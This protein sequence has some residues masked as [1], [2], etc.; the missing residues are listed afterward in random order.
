MTVFEILHKLILGPVEL[1]F[2]VIFSCSMDFSRSALFSIVV[3]SLA[4]NLLVLPLYKKAD[5]LQQEE[6]ETAKRLKPRID[7]IKEAFTGDERFMI[8]Q[9]F[10]RQ[11]NYK[12]YYVLRGSLSLLLQIPFFMAAYNFLSGLSV[13]KGVPF[14]PLGIVDLSAPDGILK[15][16]GTAVNLLPVAM[17]LIN[18]VS[19]MIYTRGQ[20]LKSKIQ[21][22]GMALVFLVLLYNS[23]AGLVIYWTLNNLFSLGKN[24]YGKCPRLR[25][26]LWIASSALGIALAVFIAFRFGSFEKR[27][28]LWFVWAAAAL[29]IPMILHGL[30]KAVKKARNTRKTGKPEK[31]PGTPKHTR[32]IFLSCCVLLT[33]LTGLLIPSAVIHDSPSEFVEI[34]AFRS[35]LIYVLHALSQDG[36]GFFSGSKIVCVKAVIGRDNANQRDTLKVQTLCYHL[37]S[38]H[39]GDLLVHESLK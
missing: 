16:G 36:K 30:A 5:A 24:I 14:L 22:Y 15:L 20:P 23:P 2:D 19:G 9:A 31:A 1:L 8:L 21:L 3:L 11:N 26:R 13:L 7:Q 35:P 29:Q 38:D 34:T 37:G 39:N 27:K 18:I 28:A 32:G 33:V 10:Y 4:I 6:N 25:K 17:T 12:P